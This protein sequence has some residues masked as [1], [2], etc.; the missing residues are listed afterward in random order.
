MVLLPLI[1][2]PT[3]RI[4]VSRSKH[5]PKQNF[6][7]NF[8]HGNNGTCSSGAG[9]VTFCPPAYVSFVHQYVHG[10]DTFLLPPLP[11]PGVCGK[12]TV[13]LV[14]FGIVTGLPSNRGSNVYCCVVT[15]RFSRVHCMIFVSEVPKSMNRGR[16]IIRPVAWNCAK[17]ERRYGASW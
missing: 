4:D 7:P 13:Q 16:I 1:S 8:P 15:L 14:T 11:P 10:L 2:L 5:I 3:T 9:T 12:Y 6:A 17:M